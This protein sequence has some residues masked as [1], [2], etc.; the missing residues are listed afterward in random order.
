LAHVGRP[1][2]VVYSL[3]FLDVQHLLR[4]RKKMLKCLEILEMSADI[5]GDLRSF[6]TTLAAIPGNTHP[7]DFLLGSIDTIQ[8]RFRN[9]QRTMKHLLRSSAG[10]L[11][12]VSLVWATMARV[13]SFSNLTV[14]RSPRYLPT[15]MTSSSFNRGMSCVTRTRV[16][17]LL[18]WRHEMTTGSPWTYSKGIKMTRWK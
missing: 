3:T 7:S 11:D 9:H 14:D 6:W 17:I 10:A 18:H 16:Q 4:V 13:C 15:G 2:K 12:M 8:S 5:V 1:S